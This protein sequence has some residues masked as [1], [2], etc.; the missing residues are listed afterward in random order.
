MP[1][2]DGFVLPIKKKNIPA[3][4][5]MARKAS[6][7]W[8][9]YGALDYK[10]CVGDDLKTRMGVPFTKLA[11]TRPGETVVFAWITYRSKAHRDRVNAKIMADPRIA[12][13]MD[14]KSPPFDCNRMA[15]GGFKTLVSA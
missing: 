14:P 7:I 5:K 8:R 10:E 1:Y 12:K 15:Y 6:R 3:Y 13:M 2:V 4:K 11:Q 9:E